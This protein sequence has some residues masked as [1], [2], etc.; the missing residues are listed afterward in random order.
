[1]SSTSVDEVI[2]G[3][4]QEKDELSMKAMM[5]EMQKQIASLTMAVLKNSKERQSQ[6]T[7]QKR[8]SNSDEPSSSNAKRKKDELE[9]ITDSEDESDEKND[10]FD[11]LVANINEPECEI[12]EDDDILAELSECFGSDDK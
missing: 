3:K 10:G 2:P 1:M 6:T 7:P 5:L 11:N 8:K 4:E 9:N 12:I